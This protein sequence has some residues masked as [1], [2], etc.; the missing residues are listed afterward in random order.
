[1]HNPSAIF[2]IL[3]RCPVPELLD[4]G[5]T[6]FLGSDGVAPD[7]S[8][9]MFRH[10][11]QCMRYHRT[12]FHDPGI[13]PPGKVLEMV[14]IDA[15]KGL[16]L[17]QEIGSLEAG[18]KADLILVDLHRPHLYPLNMPLYRLMY[19]ASGSDVDTVIVDGKILME[20]RRVRTVDED[21]VLEMAQ[22]AAEQALDHASL[23][24]Y[25]ELP[26]RF[27]GVSRYG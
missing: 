13:L 1:M 22:S 5:V 7:R 6:V 4:A 20:N 21:Q 15:A 16:G 25:L 8:Y 18:K 14:T 17:E 10:M 19:F 12:Y 24:H 27:W 11:F 3:G 26:D 23:R 9:D 2:S